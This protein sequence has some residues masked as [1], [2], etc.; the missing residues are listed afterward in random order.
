MRL[1]R[2]STQLAV[3]VS[4]LVLTGALPAATATAT[5][6]DVTG[7]SARSA[8]DGVFVSW[9][10][11]SDG[12]Y[13]GAEVE[14]TTEGTTTV[15]R[16][17]LPLG[18][19]DRD[20]RPGQSAS[21][22][23]RFLGGDEVGGWSAPAEASRGVEGW[24][25]APGARTLARQSVEEPRALFTQPLTDPDARVVLVAPDLTDL[26]GTVVG[27]IPGPGTYA[28]SHVP[29]P[30][31]LFF[32]AGC[33]GQPDPSSS[34]TMTV[35]EVVYGADGAPLTVA[36]DLAWECPDGATHRQVVR[37]ASAVPV[38]TVDVDVD[39]VAHPVVRG[40]SIT[41]DVVLRNTGG[42][43]AQ[44]EAVTAS[45]SRHLPETDRACTG[46]V[47]APGA[48][49]TV[50]VTATGAQEPAPTG[51]YQLGVTA[52]LATGPAAS[53]LASVR[54]L[55]PPTAPTLARW[56]S[57]PRVLTFLTDTGAV[58]MGPLLGA[59]LER[60]ATDGSW[61]VVDQ[62]DA[63]AALSDLT[64]APGATRRYR[65][66]YRLASGW[67]PPSAVLTAAAPT[68]ARYWVAYGL[69]WASGGAA[70]DDVQQVPT[71][72][73]GKITGVAA[74]PDRRHLVLLVTDAGVQRV[75]L[76]DLLG[77][78]ARVVSSSAVGRDITDPHVSPDGARVVYA[79]DNGPSPG[80]AWV[81][82]LRTGVASSADFRGL[83]V[84]WS[85]DG[86]RYLVGPGTTPEGGARA[87]FAWV[88]PAT[89]RERA[90]ITGTLPGA[91]TAGDPATD[92]SA[93][94]SGR[95]DLAWLDWRAGVVRVLRAGSAT[96]V[97]VASA[98]CHG[99]VLWSPGGRRL[100]LRDAQV[101][102]AGR[103]GQLEAAWGPT[104]LTGPWTRVGAPAPAS[105]R[106]V[107]WVS[108]ATPVPALA[109]PVAPLVGPAPSIAFTVT[110]AD[111]PQGAMAASCRVDTGPAVACT[112]PWRPSGLTSGA[113]T[114]AVQVTDPAGGSARA[115]AAFSVDAAAPSVRS[116][117]VP[118]ALV[119]ATTTLRWSG[120]DTGGAG[121]AGYEVR[122]RSASATGSFG[123]WSSPVATTSTSRTVTPRSG[124]T[125]CYAVRARDRVGNLGA[126]SA[127]PCV[128]TVVDDRSL[129]SS[130]GRRTA[131]SP[132]WQRTLTS[133][134]GDRTSL[135][136]G[137]VTTGRVGVLV[138]TCAGCGT[139]EVRVGSRTVGRIST[140]STTTRDRRLLWV[141]AGAVRTGTLTLRPAAGATVLVD[142]VVVLR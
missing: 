75:V 66:S 56:S 24:T 51:E 35:H 89:S 48:T 7:V 81:L 54:L 3:L 5:I 49:C 107:A 113:H 9:D 88:A 140:R 20:L 129:A 1:A 135:R 65:A 70:D 72:V 92:L 103:R 122:S 137:T 132:A 131:S 80:V 108:T 95:G 90:G 85:P 125:T 4:A 39:E 42:T 47:L 28:L 62:A 10:H 19:A 111:D 138:R 83:P 57:S 50:H 15:V 69:L 13:G 29:A 55:D 114:V 38:T 76:T 60:E 124:G 110:D 102:C 94:L 126:W 33:S 78:E 31:E 6:V 16:A 116:V 134:R 106:Q 36:A 79:S 27:R 46:V 115:T 63:G 43:P 23:V 8:P 41:V 118:G 136:L 58:D 101:G 91:E 82:D 61:V 37:W 59:R 17:N 52:R 45:L 98:P 99:R 105:V 96:P 121:V 40:E 14:R 127:A 128:S 11:P 100:L 104:G 74:H 68:D 77:R 86:T 120:A 71:T 44:V 109:L 117:S 123:A 141:P 25:Q 84:G 32:T 34:G 12:R 67:T 142:G 133:L 112:S 26:A 139:L 97:T 53:G 21:Y 93:D 30:G 22:R 130:G 64:A 119:G 18:F 87:G 2:P 73:A